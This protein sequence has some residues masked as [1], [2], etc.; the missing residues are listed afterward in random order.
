MTYASL[1]HLYPLIIS[2]CSYLFPMG[3]RPMCNLSKIATCS[4]PKRLPN[5]VMASVSVLSERVI[6]MDRLPPSPPTIDFPHL[7]QHF[8]SSCLGNFQKSWQCQSTYLLGHG[9]I[10]FTFLLESS[11]VFDGFS[12]LPPSCSINPNSLV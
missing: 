1:I 9:Y 11:K 10:N 2:R 7:G 6:N 5:R 4:P 12:T 3:E 8:P